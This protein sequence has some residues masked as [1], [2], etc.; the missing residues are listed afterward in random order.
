MRTKVSLNQRRDTET[1]VGPI[2]HKLATDEIP[3]WKAC[4]WNPEAL[5]GGYTKRVASNASAEMS[6]IRDKRIPLSY[7]QGCASVDVQVEYLNG[8]V[9]TGLSGGVIGEERS[10]THQVDLEFSFRTVDELLPP[11]A[12][13]QAA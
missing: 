3:M 5:P 6:L 4:E 11:G 1:R 7:Y 9:M 13:A 10:D 8:I 2:S 12:L